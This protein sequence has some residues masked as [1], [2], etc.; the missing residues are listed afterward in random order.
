[1]AHGELAAA[2]D[3]SPRRVV[4]VS[5]GCRVPAGIFVSIMAVGAAFGRMLGIVV[6]TAYRAYPA[7]G[8]FAYYKPDIYVIFEMASSHYR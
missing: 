6:N 7:S 1:M 3:D 5:T 8:V 4:V 2:R